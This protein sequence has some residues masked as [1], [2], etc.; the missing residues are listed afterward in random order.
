MNLKRSSKNP[1]PLISTSGFTLLEATLSVALLALLAM[2][3]SAP[4][5]SGF[6]ALDAQA[7][8]MLLD[9]QLRSR[10]EVLISTEFGSLANGNEVVT[11]RGQTYTITWNVANV[12]LDGDATPENTAKQVTVSVTELPNRAL[13]TILVDHEGNVGKIS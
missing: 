6:Q 2:T 8:S 11:V 4:Y 12:D 5:I 9:S 13:T 1:N 3:I 10:M 7:D